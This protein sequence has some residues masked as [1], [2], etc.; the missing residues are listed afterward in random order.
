VV[1][2]EVFEKVALLVE[3][4]TDLITER[5]RGI[6]DANVDYQFTNHFDFAQ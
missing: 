3:L 2:I 1:I 4:L 6:V 5:S